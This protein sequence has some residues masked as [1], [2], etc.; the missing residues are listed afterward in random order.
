MLSFEKICWKRENIDLQIVVW[1]LFSWR[2]SKQNQM[3]ISGSS[4]ASST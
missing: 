4:S 3:H 2:L 1:G